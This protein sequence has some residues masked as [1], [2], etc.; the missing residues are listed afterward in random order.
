MKTK[1]EL[2]RE[3]S[4]IQFICV[5]LNL[6]IDTHPDDEAAWMDYMC[7]S[8]KLNELINEYETMCA[9]LLGFGHLSSDNG[10]WVNARW[11]WINF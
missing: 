4:E 2:M 9:P 7:Y 1:N 5:E 11:P 6:Y 3:L 8:E 10:S